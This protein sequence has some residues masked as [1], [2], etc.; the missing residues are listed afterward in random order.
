MCDSSFSRNELYVSMLS[1]AKRKEKNEEEIQV[2]EEK[3]RKLTVGGHRDWLAREVVS[4]RPPNSAWWN[5]TTAQW[6][7]TASHSWQDC[8]VSEPLDRPTRERESI[9]YI[10]V[11]RMEERASMVLRL[12]PVALFYNNWIATGKRDLG[13]R[14][15]RAG[16][17]ADDEQGMYIPDHCSLQ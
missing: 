8:M 3:V 16:W 13:Q 11:R 17:E 6:R 5:S 10:K 7:R 2:E 12:K 15:W 1:L 9:W 14:K 4:C